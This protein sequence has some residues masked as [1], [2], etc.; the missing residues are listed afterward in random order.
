[1]EMFEALPVRPAALH[2][3][4]TSPPADGIVTAP[5]IVSATRSP[6]VVVS[7]SAEIWVVPIRNAHVC[8]PPERAA[9]RNEVDSA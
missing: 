7:D 2:T 6:A 4:R 1:M 5:A 8:V 3:R 9:K